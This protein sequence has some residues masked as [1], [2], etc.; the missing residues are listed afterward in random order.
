MANTG[1]MDDSGQNA[2]WWLFYSTALSRTHTLPL[3]LSLS[4][5]RYTV[6]LTFAAHKKFAMRENEMDN[7]KSA[8]IAR[9]SAA[10]FFQQ[11][12]FVTTN[13]RQMSQQKCMCGREW[14]S[15]EWVAE[16]DQVNMIVFVCFCFGGCFWERKQISCFLFWI[17][18]CNLNGSTQTHMCA[19]VSG[20]P[21]IQ[22]RQLAG[23]LLNSEF[24][25]QTAICICA[26][27][28]RKRVQIGQMKWPIF[29]CL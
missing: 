7:D 18:L 2:S 12:K 29:F 5:S 25:E 13:S 28:Q 20:G 22:W 11:V 24:I 8:H 17:A 16:R 19:C 6:H 9:C 26:N 1:A 4:L 14:E 15:G 3:S 27:T 21:H 23:I 10:K